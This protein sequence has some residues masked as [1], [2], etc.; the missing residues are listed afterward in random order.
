MLRT[1]TRYEDCINIRHVNW[2]LGATGNW[3]VKTEVVPMRNVSPEVDWR[4]GKKDANR[5]W[6]LELT[7]QSKWLVKARMNREC[8]KAATQKKL[9]EESL[10]NSRDQKRDADENEDLEVLCP[11]NDQYRTALGYQTHGLSENSQVYDEQGVQYV[12]QSVS[13]QKVQIKYQQIDL[14]IP[15]LVID[16]LS[17][18]KMACSN[19]PIHEI[20][21][22]WLV[23]RLI[24]WSTAAALTARL[25]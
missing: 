20:A 4:H 8:R 18:L 25:T 7:L 3:A 5:I 14:M 24:K 12:C 23:P 16:F 2:S 13:P 6:N 22:M 10:K 19:S 17:A 9:L 1:T 21:A 11:V 15:V